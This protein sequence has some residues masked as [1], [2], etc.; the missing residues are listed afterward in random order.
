MFRITDDS[1]DKLYR[2]VGIREIE[3]KI[4]YKF[5]EKSFLL[6]VKKLLLDLLQSKKGPRY[7][8]NC[9][10]QYLNKKSNKQLIIGKYL[11]I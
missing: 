6:Q 2:T 10:I 8:T 3:E 5:K 7:L 9:L 11:M 4:G 1:L